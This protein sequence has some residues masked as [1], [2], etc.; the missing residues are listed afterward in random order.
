MAM[1]SCAASSGW[2]WCL[3]DASRSGQGCGL[4]LGPFSGTSPAALARSACTY[5]TAVLTT[6]RSVFPVSVRGTL[7]QPLR[8]LS[9]LQEDQ[10][11]TLCPC[12]AQSWFNYKIAVYKNVCTSEDFHMIT[13]IAGVRFLRGGVTSQAPPLEV[14]GCAEF[15]HQDTSVTSSQFLQLTY[16]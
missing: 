7:D 16:K 15:P 11:H 12:R 9:I 14:L 13:Q 1:L 10:Q 4:R 2:R 8:C 3:P 6:V 5:F